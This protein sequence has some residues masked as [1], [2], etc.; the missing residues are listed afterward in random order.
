MSYICQARQV[1]EVGLQELPQTHFTAGQELFTVLF[2]LPAK[3]QLSAGY[4]L[5]VLDK[6][7]SKLYDIMC[8]ARLLICMILSMSIKFII[9]LGVVD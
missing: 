2:W 6:W 1:A 8:F 5:Q 3:P 4:I 9:I 7:S